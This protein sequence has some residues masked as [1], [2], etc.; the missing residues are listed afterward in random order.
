LLRLITLRGDSQGKPDCNTA[1]EC[2]RCS[3]L[4]YQQVLQHTCTNNDVLKRLLIKL[5]C[6]WVGVYGSVLHQAAGW[7]QAQQHLIY[8]V[9]LPSSCHP[10]RLWSPGARAAAAGAWW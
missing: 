2:C 7:Q 6:T 3:L 9:L 5:C 4:L 10:C 1:A 8:T